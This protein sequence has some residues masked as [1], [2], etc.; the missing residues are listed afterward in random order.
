MSQYASFQLPAGGDHN[1]GP[2][3]TA[4]NLVSF[5]LA[6]LLVATR[7]FYRHFKVKVTA[8]DDYTIIL[9]TVSHAVA[10]RHVIR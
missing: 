8:W 1:K 7:V 3:L 10:S 9:A 2:A 4:V 5:I 6:V